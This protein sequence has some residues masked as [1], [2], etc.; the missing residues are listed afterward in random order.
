M[1]RVCS[2][3]TNTV[4]HS[5]S[6]GLVHTSQKEAGLMSR[7]NIATKL[8][9]TTV[10]KDIFIL[11]RDVKYCVHCPGTYSYITERGWLDVKIVIPSCSN[12]VIQ[13]CVHGLIH[14]SQFLHFISSFLQNKQ[15]LLLNTLETGTP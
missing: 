10:F 7:A 14:M 4:I 9:Y 13:S 5:W 8:S 6:H 11:Q 1:S 2:Y 12:T 15:D 3:K